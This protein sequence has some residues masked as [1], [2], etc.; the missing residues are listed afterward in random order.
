LE[1]GLV[2]AEGVP[3]TTRS[4]MP[5][6]GLKRRRVEKGRSMTLEVAAFLRKTMT[7]PDGATIARPGCPSPICQ[8]AR[9]GRQAV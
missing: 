3:Q 6:G 9:F 2:P 5:P 1:G 8:G 4:I 7:V